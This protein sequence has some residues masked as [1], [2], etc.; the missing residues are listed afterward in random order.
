MLAH[1]E[2]EYHPTCHALA[3]GT[4]RIVHTALL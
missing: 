2:L 4:Q 3:S 1:F